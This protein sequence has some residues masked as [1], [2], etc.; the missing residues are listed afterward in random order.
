MEKDPILNF[1]DVLGR[2]QVNTQRKKIK[3]FHSV[4]RN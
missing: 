1:L 3:N 4:Y 2:F